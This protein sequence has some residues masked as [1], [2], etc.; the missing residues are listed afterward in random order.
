MLLS[1]RSCASLGCSATV[2]VIIAIQ[3]GHYKCQQVL[4]SPSS[5]KTA[6]VVKLLTWMQLYWYYSAYLVCLPHLPSELSHGVLIRAALPAGITVTHGF[7]PAAEGAAWT[8]DTCFLEQG[9][10]APGEGLLWAR[11]SNAAAGAVGGMPW[12]LICFLPCPCVP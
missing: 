12:P 8:V 4:I 5:N 6:N 9:R 7:V 2:A 3:T 1:H 10:T 11:I